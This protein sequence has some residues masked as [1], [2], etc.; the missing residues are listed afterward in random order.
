MTE[1][2]DSHYPGTVPRLAKLLNARALVISEHGYPADE[3]ELGPTVSFVPFDGI[4]AE[5]E[6]LRRMPA[7]VRQS[8]AVQRADW[9]AKRFAP[10]DILRRA[11]IEELLR[12]RLL[13]TK[14]QHHALSS[15]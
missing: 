3:A 4:G 1:A 12:S 13:F 15:D 6:R 8:L 7:S 11:G 5:F 9:F 14:R 2:G 10:G